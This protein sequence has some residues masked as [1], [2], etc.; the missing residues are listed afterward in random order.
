MRACVSKSTWTRPKRFEKP[1]AHS[2][3]SNR[4]QA[5]FELASIEQA[6]ADPEM[7]A[8][9]L[10]AGHATFGENCA[11]CHG[12][13]GKGGRGFPNLTSKDKL[14][15]GSAEVDLRLGNGTLTSLTA[16]R[17]YTWHNFADNDYTTLDMLASG[18]DEK[19]RQFSQELRYGGNRSILLDARAKLPEATL[20][21]CIALALTYHARKKAG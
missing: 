1:C 10:A 14:W 11:A 4:L 20:R 18:I 19:Q 13:D 3:L 8:Y 7:K 17:G 5:R 16:L 15:G 12:R 9:A 6:E 2:R 21:H